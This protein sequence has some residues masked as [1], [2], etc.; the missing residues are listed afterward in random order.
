MRN[1]FL[2]SAILTLAVASPHRV[3]WGNSAVTPEQSQESAGDSRPETATPAPAPADPKPKKKKKDDDPVTIKG[4]VF[5]RNTITYDGWV[6]DLGLDSARLGAVYRDR[7]TG[8]RIEVEAELSGSN[9]KVRDAHVRM[10]ANQ[11]VRIQ[12]GRF[13]RPISVI[14]LTSRWDLP[15]LDRGY[16]SDLELPSLGTREPDQLPLGGR[17]LGVSTRL[18]DKDLPGQPELSIG[19]FRSL[20]HAQ[21]AGASSGDRTPLGW[22]GQFPEDVFSRL[23]IEPMPGL[24]V[25]ASL[26]WVGQLDTAGNR[27]TFRHGF[28]SGLD[29]VVE[30]GPFRG[31]IEAFMGASPLHLTVEDLSSV[32][33]G[34]F[35]AARAI[36]SARVPVTPTIY[37]EPYTAFQILN[38]SNEVDDDRI[39]QGGGG[40]NLGVGERWR[41]QTAVDRASVGSNPSLLYTSA[42]LF[43]VQLSAA[44]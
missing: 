37:V 8:M 18:R 24:K 29:A 32:A 5:F 17:A 27:S 40:V 7:A 26:A 16:L 12:A 14:S 31:W 33:K 34:Q 3:V 44:F 2:C 20:V 4:R 10:D 39:L 43:I 41:L 9:V 35:Q 13:K 42:T 22:S 11:H 1:C 6:N 21:V 36:A 15:V 28:V 30:M 25:G 19:V 23:E 38:S